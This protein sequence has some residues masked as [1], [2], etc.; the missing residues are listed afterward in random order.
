MFEKE[1]HNFMSWQK[2]AILGEPFYSKDIWDLI[3]DIFILHDCTLEKEPQLKLWRDSSTYFDIRFFMGE[4]DPLLKTDDEY[5]LSFIRNFSEKEKRI[6]RLVAAE[7][8]ASNGQC[9]I[10]TSIELESFFLKRDANTIT[11]T[12]FFSGGTVISPSVESDVFYKRGEREILNDTNNA[13]GFG[14]KLARRLLRAN[15]N[16]L[17]NQNLYNF[18]Q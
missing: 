6:A 9:K 14:V 10:P 17:R 4:L 2:K 8:D 5:S 3:T 11:M 7:M 18:E 12:R 13:R 15:D 1:M 16:T